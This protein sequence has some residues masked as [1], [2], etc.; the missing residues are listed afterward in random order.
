MKA[1]DLIDINRG[2][3]VICPYCGKV[4]YVC[5]SILHTWGVADGGRGTCLG[6]KK[7][8]ALVFNY[9]TETMTAKRTGEV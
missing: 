1:G 5:L 3:E 2:Y 7:T 9:E 4:Q 6:C 8:M